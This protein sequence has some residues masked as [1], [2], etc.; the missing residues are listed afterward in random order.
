MAAL[1]SDVTQ[2]TLTGSGTQDT[3]ATAAVGSAQ[4]SWSVLF[5]NYS[6]SSCTLTLYVNGTASQNIIAS[7]TLDASGGFS[8]LDINVGPSDYLKAEASAA[9][10]IAWTCTKGILT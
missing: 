8:T 7:V 4:E 5:R 6:G 9:T 2:G 10:S 3:I 1:T